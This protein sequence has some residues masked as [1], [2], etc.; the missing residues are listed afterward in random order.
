MRLALLLCLLAL[1]ARADMLGRLPGVWGSTLARADSCAVNPTTIAISGTRITFTTPLPGQS[2][3]GA[4]ITSFGGTILA[5]DATTLE[6]L[7]DNETRRDPAGRPVRWFLRLD[8]AS[9]GY[10]WQ[11][12]DDPQPCIPE[13]FRCGQDLALALPFS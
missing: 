7:R 13:W 1:P 4:M 9:G 11:R 2:Y 8:P 10:C 6:M 5:H 12:N 3:T